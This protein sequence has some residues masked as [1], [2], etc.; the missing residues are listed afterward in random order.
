MTVIDDTL[1][2]PH[3]AEKIVAHLH[4]LGDPAN[5][6][7][8]ARFGINPHT[9][10]GVTIPVL[11][12]LAR[13]LKPVG[14]A[15]PAYVHALA[16]ALWE[17]DVHEAQLLATFIDRPE[18]VTPAQADAWVADLDSWDTCDQLM[19]LMLQVPFAYDK[20][21]E[22][23][24]RDEEFVRRAGFVLLSR[25]AVHDKKAPDERFVDLLGLTL[26]HCTDERTYVK[27]GVN[28]A[29]R[30][31]GKRSRPCHKAAV[32]TAEKILASHP[33]SRS[34]RWIARDALRELHGPAIRERLALD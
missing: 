3:L 33:D 1:E 25:L 9:A 6:E 23:I 13:E 27:K 12:D 22:W 16:G 4:G 17:T 28:W 26:V 34:A 5:V 18:Q 32:Q 8:M 7:G 30:Q 11:R 29:I 31:I 10:V 19:G 14:N 21:T 15:D 2:P 24:A 20:V